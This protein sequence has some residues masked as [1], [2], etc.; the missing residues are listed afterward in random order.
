[1]FGAFRVGIVFEIVQDSARDKHALKGNI[2]PDGKSRLGPT[3]FS[4]ISGH[5]QKFAGG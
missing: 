2:P 4:G 5:V 1:M 3:I